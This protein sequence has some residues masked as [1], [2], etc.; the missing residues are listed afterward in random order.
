MKRQK[1][2]TS[3]EMILKDIDRAKKKQLALRIK[4]DALDSAAEFYR[5]LD[6]DE[7]RVDYKKNR[8]EAIFLFN[9][10]ARLET[11]LI[12]LGR[13]LSEFRTIPLGE[14]LNVAGLTDNRAVLQNIKQ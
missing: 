10:A 4:S 12:K 5:T 1:K 14:R 8:N 6:T 9:K 13:V 3:E 2:Y 11:R 7:S